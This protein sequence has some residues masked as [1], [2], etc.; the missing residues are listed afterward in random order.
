MVESVKSQGVGEVSIP[1]RD[2]DKTAVG[3][4]TVNDGVEAPPQNSG[5][6]SAGALGLETM[7]SLQAI[8]PPPERDRE[9]RRRGAAMLAAL[10][11]LQRAILTGSDTVEA[12]RA[13]NDAATGDQ[14]V[15]DP[16]LG[17][18]LRAVVLRTRV[19]IARREREM[20]SVEG[21]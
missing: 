16:A 13:L 3:G 11:V 10:T 21:D 14:T 12:L 19:E 1:I 8:R 17:E 15:D 4:F 9:A 2:A 20:G 5:V 6:A 18:I 7:L